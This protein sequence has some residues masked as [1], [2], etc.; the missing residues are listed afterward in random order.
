M[1]SEA[2]ELK[3]NSALTKNVRDVVK[4]IKTAIIHEDK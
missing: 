3:K 2:K 4:A 1:Y